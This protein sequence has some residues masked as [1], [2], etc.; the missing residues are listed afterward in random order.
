MRNFISANPLVRI[1]TSPPRERRKFWGGSCD[2][3]RRDIIYLVKFDE[4]SKWSEIKLDI[5]GEYASPYTRIMSGQNFKFHYIDA[6][7][8]AGMH[9]SRDS[10]DAVHGS[11]LRVMNTDHPFHNYFFVDL[12]GGKTAFLEKIC[13]QH[14]PDRSVS[15]RTG[16]CN[17]VLAELLPRFQYKNYDR[18]FCLLDPYGL[19]L[20]WEIIAQMGESKIVDL[21][22]NFPVM[23]MNR[24]AIWHDQTK[25][26]QWGIDRMNRFWGDKT[27]KDVAYKPTKQDNLFGD[28]LAMKKQNNDAL[29]EAFGNRLREVAKFKYVPKPIPMRN[30]NNAVVYY[31]FFASQNQTANKIASDVFRKYGGRNVGN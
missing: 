26:P 19:Q 1:C 6:F 18:L 3:P 7:C 29:T 17:A 15:V 13:K 30:S 24:N 27:W 4:I 11:P 14:F 20:N 8:G 23:D 12:D 2:F 25:V 22:L 10:K 21:V 5:I 28:P 16:D 9:I 31:L